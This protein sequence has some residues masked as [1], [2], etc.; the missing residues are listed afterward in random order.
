M[1]S[2]L[3]LSSLLLFSASVYAQ[4]VQLWSDV[5]VLIDSYGHKI[6]PDGSFSTGE[7]I[8][9]DAAWTR[10]NVSGEVYVF[11]EASCGDGNNVTKNHVVVGTDKVS[12]KGAFLV[13]N[14]GGEPSLIPS[15]GKYSESYVQGITWD[16]TR[17]VG[18]LANP[19]S[20]SVDEIDPDLQRMT[21]LPFY[22]DVDPETLLASEP[23]FLPVPKRDFFDLVPQYCTAVW[24]SDDATTILGQVIDNS[25]SYIY[26][27]VYKQ[28][29]NGEW[30]YSLPSEKLFN[31]NNLEIPKW[32]VPAME[33]PLA[34][35]YIGNPAFKALFEEMLQAYLNGESYDDP[36]IMLNPEEAG[37][38]ALMT[39]EEWDAYQKDLDEYLI[40]YNTV[41]MEE[42]DKY[43][44]AYSRFIAQSTRFL[45][46]SMTMNSAGTKIGQ[47]RVVTKF[48]GIDP[49][50]FENPVVFNLEDGSYQI[51]GGDFEELELNQIL[52]DN[53]LIAASPKPGPTSPDLTP[54]HSYVCAPGSTIF[55]PIEDYIREAN[56]TYYDW[57]KEYL[58]HKIPVGYEEDGSL[59]EKEM[60]VTGLVAVSDDFSALSGGVDSWSW[61]LESGSY[62]TYFFNN[63]KSPNASIDKIE[64]VNSSSIKVFNLQGV[65]IMEAD[66]AERL[67]TLPKGIYIINGKKTLIH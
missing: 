64:S 67:N 8:S 60:T 2:Y 27:I 31:P 36:F 6:S 32:P 33:Q 50:T 21:Y 34:Q 17:L 66:S 42:M 48:Q 47:T 57:Y 25:G 18:F 40:Y 29:A 41:Y 3:V 28:A 16:G 12:M 55:V 10:D 23:V 62:F 5:P 53:T 15:L 9:S 30:S 19:N 49:I 58:F 24:I 35:N 26:P 51:Y 61:N 14:Q 20:G 39:Q 52:P 65:K 56:P 59:Y 46:S 45:Q 54:K 38:S 63:L 22:C 1:K 13:P 44:D 4:Q 7:A 43:Y 37:T 11:Q